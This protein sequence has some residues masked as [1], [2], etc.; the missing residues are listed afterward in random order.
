MLAGVHTDEGTVCPP[1]CDKSTAFATAPRFDPSFHSQAWLP[2]DHTGLKALKLLRDHGGFA[3]AVATCGD[4]IV[5][6]AG[7]ATGDAP[8][9]VLVR[10]PS[11]APTPAGGSVTMCG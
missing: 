7:S 5:S 6:S 10:A 2:S 4:A 11:V 9:R 1:S 3:R 8:L